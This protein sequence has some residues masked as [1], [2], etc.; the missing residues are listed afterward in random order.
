MKRAV[1]AAAS[2]SLLVL[3]SPVLAGVAVAIRILDGSPVLFR[4]RRPGLDGQVFTL[5]KFRTM[6]NPRSDENMLTSDGARVT[7]VGAFLRKTSLDELPELWNVLKGEMSLVGPRP[8]LVEYLP[9]YSDKHSRRH[10]MRPGVTGLA[11]VS[12]RRAL[13]LGQRLD[14]DVEYVDTWSPALDFRILIRTLSEPFKK[15]SDESQP[16]A[17]VDDVGFFRAS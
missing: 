5:V 3:G 6:R 8:L 9:K 17:D 12:G 11:Q 16:L 7:R 4:Q 15:G 10:S 2:C 14:L 1:D 13:T